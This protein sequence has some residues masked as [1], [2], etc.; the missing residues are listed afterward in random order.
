M[1]EQAGKNKKKKN[2]YVFLT[3]KFYEWQPKQDFFTMAYFRPKEFLCR[4][5]A[6][7]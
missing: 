2:V 3:N 6:R 7:N 5:S 4:P 1:K